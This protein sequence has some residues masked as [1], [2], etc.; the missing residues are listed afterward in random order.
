MW[1]HEYAL[2]PE[3]RNGTMV[4]RSSALDFYNRSDSGYFSVYLFDSAAAFAIRA[5]GDSKGFARFPVYSDRLWIDVDAADSSE[6]EV[7]RVRNYVR[8]LTRQFQCQDLNFTV[9]DSGS[10]G[11]HIA[12]KIEPMFGKDAPWSQMIYVQQSLKVTC[13][14]SLYQHGRLLSNPGRVH[15]KTGRKKTKV[16]SHQGTTILSIPTVLAPTKIDVDSDSLTNADLGRI[17]LNR[18]SSL[19]LD[20]PLP[21]MR[22]TTLWSTASQCLEA[23][24]N[25]DTVCGLLS[26]VNKMLPSPKT[27]E[28]V[29][30]CVTQ[31]ISQ[32]R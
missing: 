15:P 12:I 20:A 5:Q 13:D 14:Y 28:E 26:W 31:A 16:Y 21:G 8:D 25:E 29:K 30:R 22:H 9:W 7:S 3:L 11:Y 6:A 1:Y 2:K 4:P 10:K 18:V 24:L 23:G 17:A 32:M 19:L 27:D